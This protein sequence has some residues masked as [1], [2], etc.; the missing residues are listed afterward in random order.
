M[1]GAHEEMVV[2]KEERILKMI[3]GKDP[4]L[5][6]GPDVYDD[7][8]PMARSV[9]VRTV[10]EG[11]PPS[12]PD[13]GDLDPW[14]T[15]LDEPRLS[16]PVVANFDDEIRDWVM[17]DLGETEVMTGPAGPVA[18]RRFIQTPAVDVVRR[19][20]RFVLKRMHEVTERDK[21]M[22]P[23]LSF[24]DAVAACETA[25]GLMRDVMAT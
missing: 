5:L 22:G 4:D 19:K 7:M 8:P 12:L 10:A 25:N 13:L 2:T 18:G 14:N 24:E 9:P 1:R 16:M 15:R 23:G 20:A 6:E 11:G 17:I 3:F 21:V